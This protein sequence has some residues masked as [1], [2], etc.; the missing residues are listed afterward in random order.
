MAI[1][2]DKLDITKQLEQFGLDEETAELYLALLKTGPQGVVSIAKRL[3]KGRNVIYRLI[4]ELESRQLVSVAGKSFGKE[5]TALDPAAFE[6]L[7]ARE[8]GRTSQMRASL[9]TMIDGLYA[10]AGGK[11]ASK[12]VHYDGVEGLKQVNWNLTKAKR[13]YRVFELSHVSDYLDEA[14]SENLRHEWAKRGIT[15]YDLTNQKTVE[16]YSKNLEYLLKCSKYR[17]IDPAILDIQYEMFI[18]NDVVTLLDYKSDRLHAV[19]IHDAALS[20][21]QRQLF[22]AIW[23]QGQDFVMDKKTGRRTL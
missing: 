17:Y 8:E 3:N 20:C 13:E 12:I 18:Y 6:G 23:A 5:Y 2:Q 10:Y 22:D 15:S 9:D 1:N 16:P 4:A 7:I 19:E 14:F 11:G 21:M